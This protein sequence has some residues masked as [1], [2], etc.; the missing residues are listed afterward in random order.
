MPIARSC[1]AGS[2]I[3]SPTST[4]SSGSWSGVCAPESSAA[5]VEQEVGEPATDDG[6]VDGFAFDRRQRGV[7]DL[8]THSG[9]ARFDERADVGGVVL[10]VVLDAEDV[11]ADEEH[12]MV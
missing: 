8:V 2:A 3:A 6:V 9:P 7:G 12:R 5:A 4:P 10:G 11:V 1:C